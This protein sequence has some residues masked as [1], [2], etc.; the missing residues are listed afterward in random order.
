MHSI[1][2][3]ATALPTLAPLHRCHGALTSTAVGHCH[4][5]RGPSIDLT[6]DSLDSSER[7]RPSS[8]FP[9]LIE[10]IPW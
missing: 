7:V 9:G 2:T 4:R 1:A 8:M 5:R 3:V 10:I 6:V